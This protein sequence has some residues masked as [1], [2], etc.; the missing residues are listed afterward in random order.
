[1]KNRFSTKHFEI[2]NA[3]ERGKGGNSC[4]HA[5]LCQW[6]FQKIHLEGWYLAW[7]SITEAYQKKKRTYL[8][9]FQQSHYAKRW[10]KGRSTKVKVWAS[11]SRTTPW[12]DN[13]KKLIKSKPNFSHEG[14]PWMHFLSCFIME[15]DRNEVQLASCWGVVR[16]IFNSPY[17]SCPVL[18]CPRLV[19]LYA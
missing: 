3:N 11:W 18:S 9:H 15:A 8:H 12:K 19:S 5:L 14:V 6:R 4:W 1:M 13:L 16:Q 2:R 10:H 7:K 17:S